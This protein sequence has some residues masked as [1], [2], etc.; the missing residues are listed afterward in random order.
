MAVLS[1]LFPRKPKPG[2]DEEPEPGAKSPAKWWLEIALALVAGA[3]AGLLV[4][5]TVGDIK[6]SNLIA[7]IT[8]ILVLAITLN[9]RLKS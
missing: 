5:Y 8:G 6:M 7:G 9:H 3:G 1:T 2:G 4:V